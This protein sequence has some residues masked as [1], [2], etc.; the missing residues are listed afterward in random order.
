[1]KKNATAEPRK[2]QK[3]EAEENLE[4]LCVVVLNVTH[5]IMIYYDA[6]D[7]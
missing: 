4:G 7:S 5:W 2:V 6:I 1:M 3:K